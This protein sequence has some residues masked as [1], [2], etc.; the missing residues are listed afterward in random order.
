[1]RA[2][3]AR[4]QRACPKSPAAPV[5]D[6]TARRSVGLAR[7]RP[8]AIRKRRRHVLWRLARGPGRRNRLR[9]LHEP[10]NRRDRRPR[11]A[12]WLFEDETRLAKPLQP[13][14]AVAG[15]D[16]VEGRADSGAAGAAG[17]G[18]P[19]P[20]TDRRRLVP[21][22]ARSVAVEPS[23]ALPATRN[24][25][26][27]AARALGWLRDRADRVHAPEGRPSRRSSGGEKRSAVAQGQSAGHPDRSSDL[28]RLALI[29]AQP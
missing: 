20:T 28:S 7:L 27:R 11:Q 1:R 16:A 14:V 3:P 12:A 8:R 18:D 5:G 4:P 17:R 25:G 19:E 21:A 9:L 13:G 2:E 23:M 29:L 15:I 6:A 26:R 24:A 22:D 10:R